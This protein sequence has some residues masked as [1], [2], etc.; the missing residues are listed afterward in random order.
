MLDMRVRWDEA[1]ERCPRALLTTEIGT[2]A[3]IRK[4]AK[5]WRSE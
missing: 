2:L 4:L 3:L 5:L 1:S